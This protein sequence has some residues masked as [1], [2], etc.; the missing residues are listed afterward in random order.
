MTK[1]HVIVP[2]PVFPQYFRAYYAVFSK[3]CRACYMHLLLHTISIFRVFQ[4][5]LRQ[6]GSTPVT[7]QGRLET[8]SSTFRGS[9]DL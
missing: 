7:L 5:T 8:E 3:Y 9:T 2:K 1:D 6:V 4:S